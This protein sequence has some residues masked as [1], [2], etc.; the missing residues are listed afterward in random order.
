MLKWC[1]LRVL[2]LLFALQGSA[3]T[4]NRANQ[5]E[6]VAKDWC[7][8][9]R[10]SQVLPVYPL[11]EDVQPGDTFLVQTPLS[12]QTE[13]Y[14]EKGFLPL[15]Q[16]VVRLPGLDY[17]EFYRDA[18]WKGTY[19]SI[20]HERP[21]WSRQNTTQEHVKAPRAAFPTYNFSVQRGIGLQ[22]AIPIQGIPA[23]MGLMGA[24]RA[25]GTVTLEDAYTYGIQGETLMRRL[26]KWW[27][28]AA[29][30]RTT[31]KGIAG[32]TEKSIYLRV[33]SRVYLSNS[34]VVSL[35]NLD[36]VSAGAD[37]GAAPKLSLPDL[38]AA[39]P[40]KVEASVK[41]YHKALNGLSNLMNTAGSLVPG[42]ALRFANA[43]QRSVTMVQRFDR[44]L[45]I[46][47]RG[48]DVQVMKDG[49][50]SAPIPSFSVVSGELGKSSFSAIKWSWNKLSDCY[51]DWLRKPGNYE[52]M[53]QWLEQ[54]KQNIDPADLMH[55][56]EHLSLL[57]QAADHFGFACE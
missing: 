25:T 33:V 55:S 46:G 48:F 16:L 52:K 44:P 39:E 42:G 9:I 14:E 13:I 17:S 49:S 56:D 53:V 1:V 22:V 50:L 54:Q 7:L 2:V 21:G 51:I 3:C 23:A 20:A 37:V 18:Y 41:A 57:K 29:D 4:L 15:D 35:T 8:T 32:Q 30:V 10:A 6:R 26:V 38:S 45:V 24:S 27:S 11:S 34:V 12:Q 31:L 28:S 5:L 19:S 47:Y 40:E 36:T 43:S